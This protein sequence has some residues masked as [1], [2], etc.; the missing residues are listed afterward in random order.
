MVHALA[1]LAQQATQTGM[2]LTAV[3]IAAG[4]A[5]LGALVAA[6]TAQWRQRLELRHDRELADLTELRQVLDEAAALT[7]LVASRSG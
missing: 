1:L 6:G 3:W 7:Y 4:V 5:L 2:S